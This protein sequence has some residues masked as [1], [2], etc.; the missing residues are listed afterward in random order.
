MN[1]AEMIQNIATSSAIVLSVMYIVGGLIVNL[2]LARRGLV[3]Y[4]ILKVKYLVVGIIFLLQ[5]IGVF[6]FACLPALLLSLIDTNNLYFYEI[7]NIV[8]MLASISLLLAWAR[9][10]ASSKSYFTSWSYWFIA[11]SIGYLFPA[12]QVFREILFPL[13]HVL[14]MVIN[15]QAVLTAILTFLAQ[16]YHFSAFYYGVPSKFVGS[17]DPIG[18]GIPSR[19]KIACTSENSALLKNLGVSVNKQNVTGELFL[20]DET[21]N[22]YIVAFELLPAE[23]SHLGTLKID[24]SIVKAILFLTDGNDSQQ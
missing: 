5:V 6:V 2:N 3:E 21:D 11:S 4:Q 20:I 22:N 7:L 24:K 15:G 19:I 23:K 8:S 17:L 10:T 1:I 9:L 12:L 14:R 18:I 13:H 16:I